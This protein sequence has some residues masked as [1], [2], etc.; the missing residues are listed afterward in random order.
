MQAA[1]R[2]EVR[3]RLAVTPQDFPKA[4]GF[5]GRGRQVILCLGRLPN[6]EG[7]TGPWQPGRP[8]GG[9]RQINDIRRL[10]DWLACF[11][12]S[13]AAALRGQRLNDAEL[14]LAVNGR[15]GGI[16]RFHR[17]Y[18]EFVRGAAGGRPVWV[19]FSREIRKNKARPF[20]VALLK[21]RRSDQFML[22][23]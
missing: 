13:L 2:K 4:G 9:R 8:V 19:D 5:R 20:L 22:C 17:G 11:G 12:V 3:H 1:Q 6:L 23:S 14:G 7:L 10:S 15:R 21:L 18:L 16:D